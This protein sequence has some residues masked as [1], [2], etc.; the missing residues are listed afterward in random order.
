MILVVDIGNTNIKYGVFENDRLIYNFKQRTFNNDTS[1]EIGL[2]ICE[3]FKNL[4]LLIDEVTGVI[5]SSVVPQIMFSFIHAIKKYLH[6]DPVIVGKNLN[7]DF[8]YISHQD[9]SSAADRLVGCYW[10]NEKYKNSDKII[11]DFGTATTFDVI[12][13]S[14]KY[15]A[16]AI[17][18]GLRI[19]SEALTENTAQ[20]PRVELQYPDS[21]FGVDVVIQIQAGIIYGYIGAVKNIIKELVAQVLNNNNVE[22]IATGGFVSLIDRDKCIFDIVDKTLILDGLYNL[23]KAHKKNL[24]EQ[25]LLKGNV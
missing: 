12:D 4:G 1:D 13:N 10:A 16:G 9:I 24:C 19:L 18:P 15:L 22:I 21:L 20:L 17:L 3:V 5:I 6:K 23:Y 11:I 8:S 14:G 25:Q 2:F 7:Y